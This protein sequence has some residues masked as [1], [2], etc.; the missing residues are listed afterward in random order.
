MIKYFL[1]SLA[2]ITLFSGCSFKEVNDRPTE[3]RLNPEVKKFLT[4]KPNNFTLQIKP[5][6][7]GDL[8]DTRAI[9][10]TKEGA[11]LPYKYARWSESPAKRLE[12][13]FTEFLSKQNIFKG[14]VDSNSYALGDMLLEARVLHFEQVYKK[15][16]SSS[17]VY[18]Q[19]R[20]NLVQRDEAVLLS[21]KVFGSKVP[22]AAL[23]T[24]ESVK[25]FDEAVEKILKEIS[26]WI[27]E[28]T[29]Y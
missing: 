4:L 16:S 27:Y 14:V 26:E 5:F 8:A 23:N 3:Y 19:L 28:Q 22:V 12:Q 29:K 7:G 24:Q 10:Y 9:F 13:I 1:A 18:V 11:L 21:S 25:A 17:Y 20:V 6:S 2:I 15:K